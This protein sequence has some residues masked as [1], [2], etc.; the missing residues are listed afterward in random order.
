MFPAPSLSA[1]NITCLCW[2]TPAIDILV[3]DHPIC[4][5]LNNCCFRLQTSPPAFSHFQVFRIYPSQVFTNAFSAVSGVSEYFLSIFLMK[6]LRYSFDKIS[7]FFLRCYCVCCL[8]I[9][10]IILAQ[11][12]NYPGVYLA[13]NQE[14]LID[15]TLV[16]LG[17]NKNSENNPS[18]HRNLHGLRIHYKNLCYFE[19]FSWIGVLDALGHHARGHFKWYE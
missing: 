1:S 3:G 11:Y 13:R 7:D 9:R 6:I 8:S 17:A 16:L 19:T 5:W 2:K 10:F 4:S 14:G 12:M 18:I 15:C